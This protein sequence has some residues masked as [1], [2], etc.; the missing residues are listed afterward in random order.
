M[1]DGASEWVSRLRRYVVECRASTPVPD[2]NT[3]TNVHEWQCRIIGSS[4]R[5][6]VREYS[7]RYFREQAVVNRRWSY[8][9]PVIVFTSNVP[10][11]IAVKEII[12]T[13]HEQ[14]VFLLEREYDAS[15]CGEEDTEHGFYRHFWSTVDTEA[16]LDPEYVA[17]LRTEYPIPD[18][19]SYWRHSEG[20][21][22]GS[23]SSRCVTQLWYWDGET[24]T[25][26]EGSRQVLVS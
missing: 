21:Y 1:A 22:S 11:L 8:N 19:C 5:A 4:I 10:G 9:N 18:G 12:G 23:L 2:R 3:L 20:T 14:V 24:P 26:I 16:E 17:K 13:D 25:I 6:G 15:P 7:P